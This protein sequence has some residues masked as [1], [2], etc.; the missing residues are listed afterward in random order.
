MIFLLFS[1]GG[2]KKGGFKSVG[3]FLPIGLVGCKGIIVL[4]I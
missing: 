1:L 4:G 2:A 3:I